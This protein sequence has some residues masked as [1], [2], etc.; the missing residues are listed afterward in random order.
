V[1][2]GWIGESW[3][4]FQANAGVWIVAALVFFF[5][6]LIVGAVVGGIIGA[7]SHLA[8]S[9]FGTRP[10]LPSIL[11]G[12]GMPFGPNL[13]IRLFSWAW[14]AYFYGSVYRM[15]VAQVRGEPIGTQDIFGGGSTFVKYL[16]LSLVYGLAVGVGTVLCLI[17]GLI[18]AA[19]LLPMYAMAADGYDFGSALNKSSDAMKADLM[20]GSLFV[21][22]MGLILLVSVI[23]CFLGLLVTMPMWWIIGALAYRDMVGFSGAASAPPAAPDYGQGQSPVWPPPPGPSQ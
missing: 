1:S 18:V 16:G 13:L 5:V 11:S 10:S 19:L 7:T 4:L 15:A 21:L 6:P 20:S 2:F 22:V 12:G 9:S 8:A 3:S 23:P 14:T 17:P